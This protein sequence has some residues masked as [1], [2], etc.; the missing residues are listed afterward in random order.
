MCALDL[1]TR[2]VLLVQATFFFGLVSFGFYLK[3]YHYIL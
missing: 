3:L 2:D 1:L